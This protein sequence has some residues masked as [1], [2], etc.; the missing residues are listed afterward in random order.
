MCSLSIYRAFAQCWVKTG[1]SGS[2]TWCYVHLKPLFLP[3]LKFMY[4][5]L[6]INFH[7]IFNVDSFHRCL[8]YSMWFIPMMQKDIKNVDNYMNFLKW[9][10]VPQ[11]ALWLSW[12]QLPANFQDRVITTDLL[13]LTAQVLKL[14]SMTTITTA[15]TLLEYLGCVRHLAQCLW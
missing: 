5:E 6:Y 4:P 13:W 1:A 15:K 14:V 10:Q 11:L 9:L 8:F 3:T 7:N 2:H 12:G